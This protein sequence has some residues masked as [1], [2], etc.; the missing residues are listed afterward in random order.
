MQFTMNL[1]GC[2]DEILRLTFRFAS[3]SAQVQ[4]RL[5]CK[6]FR[7]IINSE[8]KKFQ[9]A[10]TFN[11]QKKAKCQEDLP[12]ALQALP[13]AYKLRSVTLNPRGWPFNGVVVKVRPVYEHGPN[14]KSV[15]KFHFQQD[16][17]V[18]MVSR[19]S[20]ETKTFDY[21]TNITEIY[22][23]SQLV[24]KSLRQG[25][26]PVWQYWKRGGLTEYVRYQDGKM[27]YKKQT[28]HNYIREF[29]DHKWTVTD[30]DGSSRMEWYEKDGV[31]VDTW[32]GSWKVYVRKN[33]VTK[34]LHKKND[35]NERIMTF[36]ENNL[37]RIIHQRIF[38]DWDDELNRSNLIKE[39]I[40]ERH[41]HNDNL[42][43][44]V[45]PF[46]F[47]TYKHK[48]K[49][50]N[51]SIGTVIEDIDVVSTPGLH[52]THF[53]PDGTTKNVYA[54]NGKKHDQPEEHILT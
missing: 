43:K 4:L 54:V 23:G 37:I 39:L 15:T 9:K 24:Y 50:Q 51:S 28:K 1:L 49:L 22:R 34:I 30:N 16:K 13:N 53:Y 29:K 40:S 11:C 27:V 45:L 48:T 38:Y 3:Y 6:R 25:K 7:L 46:V 41:F 31:I 44:T 52:F 33:R 2:P 21:R 12:L 26:Q 19:T 35:W 5:T 8:P 14:Q 10:G 36:T 47:K 20:T 18:R 42:I 32:V 17:L